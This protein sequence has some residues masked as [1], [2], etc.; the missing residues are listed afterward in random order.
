MYSLSLE[1]VLSL[2]EI[3][4]RHVRHILISTEPKENL[5][6]L[7]IFGLIAQYFRSST[8]TLFDIRYKEQQE[9]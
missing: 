6:D 9:C 3:H 7:G 4:L 8:E 1:R 2:T 5:I